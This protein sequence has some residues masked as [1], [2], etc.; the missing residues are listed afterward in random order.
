MIRTHLY[1]EM[2]FLIMEVGIVVV[3]IKRSFK[4]KMARFKQCQ[5]KND[6]VSLV[7]FCCILKKYPLLEVKVVIVGK[8]NI[9]NEYQT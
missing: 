6:F 7:L 4:K 1:A 5:H 9:G 8:L 2:V 3:E